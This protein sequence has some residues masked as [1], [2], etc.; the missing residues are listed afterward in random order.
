MASSSL[1]A[2]PASCICDCDYVSPPDPFLSCTASLDSSSDERSSQDE[3]KSAELS[4]QRWSTLV[5]TASGE[6][7]LV[8]PPASVSPSAA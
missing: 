2:F 6:I 4:F 5:V 7:P 8:V 3:V 1:I